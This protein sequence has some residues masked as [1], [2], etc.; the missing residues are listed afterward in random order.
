[1][2]CRDPHQ[3]SLRR[4]RGEEVHGRDQPRCTGLRPGLDPVPRAARPR[5]GAERAVGAVRRHRPRRV[6]AVRRA[7]QHADHAEAGGQRPDLHPVAHHRPLLPDAVVPPHRSQPPP[8]RL[9]P[10]RRGRAGLP[11]PHRS[12]PDGE[13]DHR[14]GAPRERLQHL[15]GRQEPQ[16]AARRV[17]GGRHQAEL[18]AGARLRQVLRL[19][20]WRD[21]Q[22]VPHAGRGQPLR[23]PARAAGGRLP[24]L[25]GPGR[26]GH[27][28]HRR[29]QDVRAAEA[30]VPLVLP[31]CEP[32]PAPRP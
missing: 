26:Q 13:R 1:M 2:G 27:L 20:R 6:V 25:E 21:Q 10:D 23:R 11:R 3:P 28:L 32:R 22:L 5:G 7:D 29:Q 14:R 18:A 8:E 24:P 4:S 15:L 30:L 17:G 16:R 9:R 31:R 19:H 12:H